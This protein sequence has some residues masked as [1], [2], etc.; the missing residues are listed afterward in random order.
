VFGKVVYVLMGSTFLCPYEI[1]FI[2]PHFL[3][4]CC[5]ITV[6]PQLLCNENLVVANVHPMDSQGGRFTM[7]LRPRGGREGGA[8]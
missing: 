2:Q 1:E 3:T 5:G 8:P 7:T 6:S 4:A